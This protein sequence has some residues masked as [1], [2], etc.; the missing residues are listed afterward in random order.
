MK[1]A[2]QRPAHSWSS[3]KRNQSCRSEKIQTAGWDPGSKNSWDRGTLLGGVHSGPRQGKG[4]R[5]KGVWRSGLAWDASGWGAEGAARR[6]PR[7][8]RGARGRR[9]RT[10]YLGREG[11]DHRQQ[12]ER[13]EEQHE[14]PPRAPHLLGQ[15]R[16]RRHL[17]DRG[18]SAAER[19]RRPDCPRPARARLKP[20][21]RGRGR[22]GARPPPAPAGGRG[23]RL[24]GPVEGAGDVR[25]SWARGLGKRTPAP[26]AAG[27][28]AQTRGGPAPRRGAG[29]TFP[30]RGLLAR[31][32]VGTQ[33]LPV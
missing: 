12:R 1:C 28:R 22:G 25:E 2:T 14:Q 27:P 10:R 20:G 11:E 18:R 3:T 13:R 7:G 30:R 5:A 26:R 6:G 29:L 24:L 31:D 16:Q 21:G 23:W 4:E 17:R 15:R 8:T 33:A 19:A 32:N 9:Q